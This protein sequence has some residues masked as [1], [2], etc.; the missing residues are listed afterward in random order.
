MIK[1]NEATLQEN[2]NLEAVIQVK[3]E[4]LSKTISF[5]VS[6]L[7][8][9]P[10]FYHFSRQYLLLSSSLSIFSSS[11]SLFLFLFPRLFFDCYYITY[12]EATIDDLQ[13]QI[14]ASKTTEKEKEEELASFSISLKGTWCNIKKI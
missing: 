8:P 4:R 9:L 1:Q 7:S 12:L 3:E 10:S 13:Q 2:K 14:A 11:S 5:F 6:S